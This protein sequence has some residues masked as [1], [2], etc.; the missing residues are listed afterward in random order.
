MASN[1]SNLPSPVD[2]DWDSALLLLELAK[3]FNQLIEYLKQ[4]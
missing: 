3:R 2:P 4:E 1:K